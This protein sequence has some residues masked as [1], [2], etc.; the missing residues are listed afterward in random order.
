MCYGLDECPNALIK[1]LNGK[2]DGKVIVK[3]NS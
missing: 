2:N 1:L 3:A